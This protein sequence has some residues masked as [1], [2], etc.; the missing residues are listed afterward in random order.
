MSVKAVVNAGKNIAKKSKYFQSGWNT[1]NGIM[2]QSN[3]PE[4]R[5]LMKYDKNWPVKI[6]QQVPN[7]VCWFNILQGY[8]GSKIQKFV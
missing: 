7:K 5:L 4:M 1:S 8:H 3:P 6:R 2:H